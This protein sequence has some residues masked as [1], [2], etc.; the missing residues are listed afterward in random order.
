M[1]KRGLSSVVTTIIIILITLVA[2]MI[3][4]T[5]VSSLMDK[6]TKQLS[7]A[8]IT[9]DTQLDSA[10]VNFTS[11]IATVRVTRNSGNGNVTGIKIMV[12][13]GKTVEVFERR[14]AI[15]GEGS[16]KTITLNL[17]ESSELVLYD[18]EKI[19][20]APIILLE[21]GEEII[22]IQSKPITGLNRDLNRTIGEESN[23]CILDSQ[24]GISGWVANTEYCSLDTTQVLQYYQNF[25][26]LFGICTSSS[27]LTVKET[28]G[29]GMF[30]YNG[31]CIIED[32]T[33]TPQTVIQ[34]CGE[35]GTVG[36]TSCNVDKTEVIQNYRNRSCA[37]GLCEETLYTVTVEQ[38]IGEE[39]CGLT[40]GGAACYIPVE[41][42]VDEDCDLGEVCEEGE[43]IPEEILNNGTINTI[44]PFSV[45]EY[46]DSMD[47]PTSID[48]YANKYIIFPNSEE[49]RCMKIIQHTY[50]NKTGAYAYVRLNETITNLSNGDYY[51]IWKTVYA[52]TLI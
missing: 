39:I 11:G 47:L 44:W 21:S 33:C 19:S 2:I 46:F 8:R 20:I 15:F 36:G 17:S 50:P 51:E 7:L 26:C 25:S 22:G 49:I 38:C 10:S 41:C 43:C 48:N 35:N 24:C 42:A 30:C 28:C 14:F 18:I 4:W 16:S 31:E 52:C 29:G 5:I 23:S 37:N 12:D 3:V 45:G 40:L 9:V 32:V 6:S 13:D 1:K 27:S 34:T